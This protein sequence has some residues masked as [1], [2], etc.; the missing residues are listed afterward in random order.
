VSGVRG[1]SGADVA[2]DEVATRVGVGVG[3]GVGDGD[4]LGAPHDATRIA[5][6]VAV[7]MG[8]E[9]RVMLG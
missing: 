8:W 4:V 2:V 7:T 3:E 9:G 1:F 5:A 6:N